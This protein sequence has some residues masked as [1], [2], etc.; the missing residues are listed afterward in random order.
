MSNVSVHA[1]VPTVKA[2]D[3]RSVP[4]FS[5]PPIPWSALSPLEMSP[6][7]LAVPGGVHRAAV[8]LV[9]P[10]RSRDWCVDLRPSPDLRGFCGGN[11]GPM[12]RIA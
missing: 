9:V 2:S 5:W 12:R 7:C 4:D 3:R 11:S 6:A 1:S 10:F 8:C